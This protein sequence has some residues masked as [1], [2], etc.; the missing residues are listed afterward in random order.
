MKK[1]VLI[2]FGIFIL[3]GLFENVFAFLTPIARWDVVPYQRINAG[4]TLNL[5]V[6]AF[7]KEGI[8]RVEFLIS[9]QGYSGGI[10]TATE[11]TLNSQTGVWEYWV[12][13]SA[14]EFSSDGVIGV[15]AVVYGRDG[16]VRDKNTG[17]GN[18]GLDELNFTVNPLGSLV[19]VEA[20]VDVNGNDLTGIVNDRNNPFRTIGKSIDKIREWRNANGF[21]NNADGGIIRLLPGAHNMSKGGVNGEIPVTNEWVTITRDIS[22]TKENTIIQHGNGGTPDVRLLKAEGTTLKSSRQYDFAIYVSHVANATLWVDDCELVG[23]GRYVAYDTYLVSNPTYYT[24]SYIHD[25]DTAVARAIFARNVRIE[26][27]SND[28]FHQTNF[29]VNCSATDLNP[30]ILHLDNADYIPN[31]HISGYDYVI[32]KAG[33]FADY[34]WV[35]GN[36]FYVGDTWLNRNVNVLGKIDDNSIYVNAPLNCLNNATTLAGIPC[37]AGIIYNSTLWTNW[38]SDGLQWWGPGSGSPCNAMENT[39]VYSNRIT[40]TSYQG[41]WIDGFETCPDAEGIAFVNNYLDGS[42]IW[43]RGTKHLVWWH[44]SFIENQ[45]NFYIRNYNQ[46]QFSSIGNLFN[47]PLIDLSSGGRVNYSSWGNNHFSFV[48]STPNGWSLAHGTQN[49]TGDAGLDSN[50]KLLF[51]S[52]LI[53]RVSPSVVPV[54]ANGIERINRGDVGAYEYISGTLP[55]QTTCTITKAYWKLA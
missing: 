20:W 41:N 36:M 22:G 24:N 23:P 49:T 3:V 8:D 21:G 27:I 2:I 14:S 52:V 55:V 4:E 44:N 35:N 46:S 26:R 51:G 38:H 54:D 33:A 5:G 42:W 28:A 6:V 17:G 9:G 30:D 43:S 16:G 25:V 31:G 11:M 32:E 40:N 13:L 50:G 10:K 18:L 19:Q 53:D 12:P 34:T 37:D 39:I 45:R 15:E 1:R 29:I 7:S 48:G 47:G